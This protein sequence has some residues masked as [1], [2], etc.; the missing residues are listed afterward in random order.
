MKSTLLK[1][2]D[3]FVLGDGLFHSTVGSSVFMQAR[4]SFKVG[5]FCHL[6]MLMHLI[7]E[8]AQSCSLEK[9]RIFLPI[10]LGEISSWITP[11]D[12]GIT[13]IGPALIT[14]VMASEWPSLR[15]CTCLEEL[16]PDTKKA[17]PPLLAVMQECTTYYCNRIVWAPEGGGTCQCQ[18][19]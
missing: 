13:G 12:K 18:A 5:L 1:Q 3:Y 16:L 17:H 10:S 11:Q 15:C 14:L 19:P 4:S 8:L 2:G 7:H 9:E 6:V